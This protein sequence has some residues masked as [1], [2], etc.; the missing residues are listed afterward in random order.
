[1]QCPVMCRALLMLFGFG[2]CNEPVM[3]ICSCKYIVYLLSVLTQV[4]KLSRSYYVCWE[5]HQYYSF[6]CF[7]VL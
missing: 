6:L 5:D 2:I 1:M 3:S 7:T 4:C